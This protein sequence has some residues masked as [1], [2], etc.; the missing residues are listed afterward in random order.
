MN[1]AQLI[2]NIRVKSKCTETCLVALVGVMMF[3]SACTHTPQVPNSTQDD[4]PLFPTPVNK[5]P[6]G[7]VALSPTSAD[8]FLIW[9]QGV[10][11]SDIG[12]LRSRIAEV[13][14]DD[15][16]I[17]ALGKRL[18]EIPVRDLSRHLMILAIL[19]ET[20]NPR[21]IDPILKFIWYPK[22]LA[23][24]PKEMLGPGIHVSQFNYDGGLRAR[25]SEM[26]A[27][28]GTDVANSHTREILQKHP[29]QEVRIAAIDAYLFN[30]QDSTIA[31]EELQR[32]VQPRE[33]RMIA[34]A[35][36]TRDMDVKAF[37]SRL[38]AFYE[39]YPDERPP[40]PT[41][42]SPRTNVDDRATLYREKS[43]IE[44]R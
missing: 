7:T 3:T 2:R 33:R 17:D 29:S 25:A 9:A 27:Y 14:H 39:A 1:I 41:Q 22:A 26:L 4:L 5:L 11:Q 13:A 38:R 34:L 19:G 44:R 32:I 23:E 37:D 30:H 8:A 21:A 12:L 36:R 10:A 6:T 40:T 43:D 15:T 35:R 31:N 28:I 20:Q 42:R 16:V 24:E 18:M